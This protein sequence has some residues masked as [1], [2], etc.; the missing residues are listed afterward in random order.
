MLMK[1]LM[2]LCCLLVACKTRKV[3][4][5]IIQT[6]S[7]T[8][9]EQSSQVRNVDS[10]KTVDKSTSQTNSLKTSENSAQGEID[11]IKIKGT[12][13]LIY[14]TKGKP[15]KYT[16][17][18]TQHKSI[19]NKNDIKTSN[20]KSLDSAGSFKQK[21]KQDSTHKTK[22]TEATGSGTIW[23]TY[24]GIG[25]GLALLLAVFLYFRKK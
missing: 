13:T 21:V 9:T 15:F 8:T 22:V 7:S 16:A 5:D 3:A 18:I 12:T 20:T 10:T 17:D 4:T 6:S 2:I 19:D 25:I 1:K 23:A 11:S 14:P 24:I